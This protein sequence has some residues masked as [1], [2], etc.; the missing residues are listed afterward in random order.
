LLAQKKMVEVE[1]SGLVVMER[2]ASTGRQ[3]Q[4]EVPLP[5]QHIFHV[6]FANNGAVLLPK[7]LVSSTSH[8]CLLEFYHSLE[9]ND[10]HPHRHHSLQQQKPY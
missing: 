8:E 9:T 7:L 6:L 2:N 4:K 10:D 3:D 5:L 1:P